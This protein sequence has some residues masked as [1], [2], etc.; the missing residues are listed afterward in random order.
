MSCQQGPYRVSEANL[1]HV[2]LEGDYPSIEAIR[3]KIEALKRIGSIPG[4]KPDTW[5]CPECSYGLNTFYDGYCV[6][7]FESANDGFNCDHPNDQ[8]LLWDSIGIDPISGYV[9]YECGVKIAK[10]SRVN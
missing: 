1:D 3:E 7:P 2:A 10:L 6:H 4:D 8:V 9:Y 5:K